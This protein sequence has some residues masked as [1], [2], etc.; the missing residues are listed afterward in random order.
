[1][2]GS[3]GAIWLHFNCFVELGW[4]G[5]TRNYAQFYLKWYLPTT[6]VGLELKRVYTR[7]IYCKCVVVWSVRV[8][9]CSILLWLGWV[10]YVQVTW[11]ASPRSEAQAHVCLSVRGAPWWV[12]LQHYCVAII[13]HRRVWY[14]ALSLRNAC[15][16]SSGIILRLPLCHKFRLFRGLPT[17]LS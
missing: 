16:R 14:R 12:L 6:Y 5:S 2:S 9:S 17:L 10:R 13:F 15:I 4:D 7:P 3:G 1:M 8:G 11:L